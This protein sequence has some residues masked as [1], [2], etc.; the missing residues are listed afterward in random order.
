MLQKLLTHR[1]PEMTQRYAHLLDTALR[2]AAETA[3]DIFRQAVCG[4]PVGRSPNGE[5]GFKKLE[6]HNGSNA[7]K[8]ATLQR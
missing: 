1:T 6:K 7:V 8:P 5:R 2:D 3:A 4:S